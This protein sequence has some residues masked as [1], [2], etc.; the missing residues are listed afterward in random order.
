[1]SATWTTP[2]YV[3]ARGG[4]AATESLP[5]PC[6]ARTSDTAHVSGDGSELTSNYVTFVLK[7]T[8]PWP[9]QVIPLEGWGQ[10]LHTRNK[11]LFLVTTTGHRDVLDTVAQARNAKV[12][13]LIPGWWGA[14][15]PPEGG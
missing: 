11:A 3:A 1:M 9:A 15:I 5:Q 6:C 12:Q 10:F 8:T 2:P 7:K 13:E 4:A 14:L